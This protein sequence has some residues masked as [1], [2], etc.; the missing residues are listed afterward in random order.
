VPSL[1]IL[2]VKLDHI[3]D[4]ALAVPALKSLA[5]SLPDH[6]L[7]VV[8]SPLNLGWRSV[9]PWLGNF[10]SVQFPGYQGG[11]EKKTSK[12][13]TIS[14]LSQ[15]RRELRSRSYQAAIDL[16]AIEGDWRG[17]LVTWLSGAP[18]R[19]G[20]PGAGG[21]FL[22][23]R[24]IP[25]GQ[26]Q[27]DIIL[28]YLQAVKPRLS[29]AKENLVNLPIGPSRSG[30]KQ[31][32]LHPGAG[33][34]AKLWPASSWSRLV[35][36]L[37]TAQPSIPFRF[38]GGPKEQPL[39]QQICL[40]RSLPLAQQ[41]ISTTISDTL[42]HLSQTDLLVGL[43]SAGVHLAYLVGTP[44]IT[45]FSILNDSARW[46]ALGDNTLFEIDPMENSLKGREPL[47]PRS[48]PAPAVT[49]EVVAQTILRKL[50]F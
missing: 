30:P 6:S 38:I 7:D 5:E 26:H 36:L 44:T 12:L 34:P 40:E 43:D 27:S 4:F 23:D 9:L 19:I 42:A 14:Q 3:G 50:T 46:K 18:R 8:V 41:I 45:L 16:R 21:F 39:I 31:V 37:Q 47:F 29:C 20:A 17:K 33:H 24:V 22:T 1:R 13:Q 48:S 49:A 28:N 11:R 2:A 15:L 32:L 25:A 10:Y 35:F